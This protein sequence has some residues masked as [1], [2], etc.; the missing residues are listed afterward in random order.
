MSF[1]PPGY[2][3]SGV[4]QGYTRDNQGLLIGPGIPGIGM[5]RPPANNPP[6]PF[7]TPQ[8][9][10]NTGG[11]AGAGTGSD[12]LSTL[13]SAYMASLGGQGGIGATAPI[14]I[15]AAAGSDAGSGI[16]W[17]MIGALAAV[18][19]VVWAVYTYWKKHHGGGA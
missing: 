7:I 19:L 15:P 1:D 16:N 4:P 2:V 11:D 6:G 17:S 12:P 18:V 5:P 9:P 3:G 13:A 8:P 14:V 10:V